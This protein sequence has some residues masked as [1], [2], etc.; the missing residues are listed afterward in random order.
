MIGDEVRAPD[1][2]RAGSRPRPLRRRS[3]TRRS[4]AAVS[5]PVK[6]RWPSIASLVRT[7]TVRPMKRRKCSGLVSGRSAPGEETSSENDSSRSRE[8]VRHPLAERQVH[9]VGAIDVEPKRFGGGALERDQLD[10]GVEVSAACSRSAPEARPNWSL[11]SRFRPP[12]PHSAPKKGGPGPTSIRVRVRKRWSEYSL[13]HR[14]AP[15]GQACRARPQRA[16]SRVVVAAG[17]ACANRRQASSIR[18]TG[19]SLTSSTAIRAPNT[20]RFAPSRSQ[21]RSYSGSACLGRRRVGEARAGCPSAGPAV[22]RELAHAERPRGRSSASFIRP[23][24]SSK[25]RSAR[26]LSASLS[27]SASVSSRARP[28]AGPGGP[29]RSPRPARP[30]TVTAARC[31]ALDERPHPALTRAGQAS[32]S[33]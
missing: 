2:G 16:S 13:A 33:R 4:S 6:L 17:S 32:R 27:A 18:V 12:P 21:N 20:P 9:P 30:S 19:P 10:L 5:V 26:T 22:E 25:T 31:D 3:R 14:L 24:S 7:R 11:W 23:S 1:P 8:L 29:G 28:R 15:P